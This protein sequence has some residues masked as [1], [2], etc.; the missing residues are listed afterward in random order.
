MFTSL[1]QIFLFILS[2]QLVL[3]FIA[4]FFKTDKLT[5]ISYS[6]TFVLVAL[7][8]LLAHP[9]PSLPQ[10]I[11]TILVSLWG[12]RL[13]VYLFIRINRIGK[14][15]RFDNIRPHFFKFLNFWL[16]QAITIWIVLLP[17]N[18]YLSDISQQK[19]SIVSVVS[20]LLFLVYLAIET[21]ADW[22]KFV[23]K[24]DPNN[25]DRWIDSGIWHYS[26]HPNYF[27]EMLVWWSVYFFVF[28]DLYGLQHL[29]IFGPLFISFMLLFVSGIPLLE[30]K[31]DQK[32]KDNF[33]YQ[34][35]KKSTSLLIPLPKKS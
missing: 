17:V 5:D 1:F 4:Y 21:V 19:L 32:Y 20:A 22:Q 8:Q 3:F 26:R 35:Y 7:Y 23:F 14:D 15:N 18:I 24:L 6:F 11:L 13:G 31:N 10:I 16:L 34:K 25:K 2:I 33:E 29:S 30:K 27:G 12:I 28:P 9:N